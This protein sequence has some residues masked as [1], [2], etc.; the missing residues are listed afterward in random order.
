MGRHI[1][2]EDVN[3]VSVTSMGAKGDGVTDDTLRSRGNILPGP[4]DTSSDTGI[5]LYGACSKGYVKDN[6]IFGYS[7]KEV[8]IS[9]DS[10]DIR[11]Q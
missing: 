6:L 8:H 3:V 1:M 11:T 10:T 2:Q 5:S 9:T 7:S 4:V